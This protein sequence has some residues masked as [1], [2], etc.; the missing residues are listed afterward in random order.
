MN[1]E[2]VVHKVIFTH[3][4]SRG[5]QWFWTA[6]ARNGRI[7]G[8]SGEGYKNRSHCRAMA[9]RVLRVGPLTEYEIRDGMG[10]LLEKGWLA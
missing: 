5:G 9:R 1:T 4:S 10:V 6:R 8:D 3:S 7:V 2:P